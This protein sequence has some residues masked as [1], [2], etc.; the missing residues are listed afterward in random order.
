MMKAIKV[1][2]NN[3]VSTVFPDSREAVL[4][5]SGIGFNKK[6]GDV[7]DKRKIEKVYYIQDELQTKF[8]QLLKDTR[9]ESLKAAEEILQYAKEQGLELKE[10]LLISLTDHIDFAIDRVEAGVNMPLLMLSE[11][12]LLYKKEY[13][14]GKWALKRIEEICNVKLPK[15]ETGYI[16]MQLVSSSLSQ[17]MA[18]HILEFVAG[19]LE[20]VE[21]TYHV[22]LNDDSLDTMRL[23][24][25]LK[26]LAQRIFGQ[27]Q[28]SDDD[29]QEL[30]HYL[31]SKHSQNQECIRRIHDYISENFNYQMNYQEEVY[32]MVHLNKIF[33]LEK[34]AKKQ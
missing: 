11:I 22:E 8:L 21:E 15:E 4:V 2:N 9:P 3:A 29:M 30:H 1:Y 33:N 19:V 25:H 16:A 12:K 7:I 6:P 28:W 5:G 26:F 13:E 32:L 27:Q 18:Y 14:I 20:I 23:T 17:K 31:L 34:T 24:T 10:Q